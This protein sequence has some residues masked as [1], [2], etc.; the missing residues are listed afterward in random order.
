MAGEVP[1]TRIDDFSGGHWGILGA[2]RADKGQ[3]GGVNVALTRRGGIAPV[4]AARRY[5]TD[6]VSGLV[7]GM[8]YAWGL[9]GLLY[10]VQIDPTDDTSAMVRRF[11]PSDVL[12]AA[13]IETIDTIP[14]P[15]ALDWTI[16][17]GF[18]Y[19]TSYGDKTYTI[20][21]SGPSLAELTDAPGGRAICTYGER[22]MIGSVD[23]GT[24][25]TQADRV[26]YSNDPDTGGFEG[27]DATNFFDVGADGGKD[28]RALVPMRDALLI[29][30]ED[31]QLWLFTGVP[32]FDDRQ[33]RYYGFD[34]AAGAIDAFLPA[35]V[36]VDPAQNRAW[37][38]DHTRRGV[39]TFFGGN[40][41]RVEGFGALAATRT[42][43]GEHQGD[44]AI[45]GGPN[46]VL[47]GRVALP[48]TDG[49]RAPG[50]HSLLRH[51][52][53]WSVID[54]KVLV[55]VTPEARPTCMVETFDK[56]D[57][58]LGPDLEWEPVA[59]W[60]AAQGP[61]LVLFP[62]ESFVDVVDVPTLTTIEVRDQRLALVKPDDDALPAGGYTLWALV[63]GRAWASES[64]GVADMRVAARW[65][66]AAATYDFEQ[67]ADGAFET[68]SMTLMARVSAPIADPYDFNSGSNSALPSWQAALYKSR[69]DQVGLDMRLVTA[70][71]FYQGPYT[72]FVDD[73]TMVDGD[74][75]ELQVEGTGNATVARVIVNGTLQIGEW[76]SDGGDFWDAFTDVAD[77]PDGTQAG[78][79]LGANSTYL[80]FGAQTRRPWV[81]ADSGLIGIDDFTV[82][83]LG[84]GPPNDD[85]AAAI[86]IDVTNPGTAT[87]SSIG[88]TAEADED[89]HA[90]ATPDV[91][92]S[93]WWKFTAPADGTIDL[94]TDGSNFDTVLALY[95]GSAVDGLS[96][97]DSND[98]GDNPPQS[99]IT[100]ASVSNGTEYHVA[101]AAAQEW[102]AGSVVLNWTFTP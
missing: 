4:S 19:L 38:Y 80:N 83:P 94:N 93:V 20:D 59:S 74:T 92:R 22:L 36:A 63:G 34:R 62:P 47:V 71:G 101:V 41:V 81:D 39:G 5:V 42:M 9:D 1:L 43:A 95:E 52:D 16:A 69:N 12:T 89:D 24:F 85:F 3:W 27:W 58:A 102:I 61:A 45:I 17:N 64:L 100:G 82:C 11:D 77:L 21:P 40:L 86:E 97:I 14:A 75:F 68:A 15:V 37:V 84:A 98:D 99:T 31:A 49:D 72:G 32:G 66:D 30:L 56:D 35:H 8:R 46:E 44:L 10:F 90:G 2:Q 7:V 60:A 57:G 6:A 54:Q 53:A 70:S 18:L 79:E 33:R 55:G 26:V 28:V 91:T 48:R 88:A 50:W 67:A 51:N 76:T 25:G 96:E 87:G 13:T 65:S 78:I 73:W 23:D 29:I